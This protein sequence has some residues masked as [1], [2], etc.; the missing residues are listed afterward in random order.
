ML[1]EGA[2]RRRVQ[3]AA[4]L[5]QAVEMPGVFG[6]PRLPERGLLSIVADRKHGVRHGGRDQRIAVARNHVMR[7]A[8][9][10]QAIEPAHAGV[11]VDQQ[12]AGRTRMFLT[13]HDA[14]EQAVAHRQ[15][16]RMKAV[17]HPHARGAEGEQT[18]GAGIA[19]GDEELSIAVYHD[20]PRAVLNGQVDGRRWPPHWPRWTRRRA[21]TRST[22]TETSPRS[23]RREPAPCRC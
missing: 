12:I 1:V 11:V 16:V 15:P 19:A 8:D 2:E 7:A 18:A 23:R 22:R 9:V 10:V 20:H 6:H 21:P 4:D 17:E 5:K 13:R 3:L 14:I